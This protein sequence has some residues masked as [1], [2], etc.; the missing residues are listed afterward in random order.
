VRTDPLIIDGPAPR[1]LPA[2]PL[3]SATRGGRPLYVLERTIHL[4]TKHGW[5]RIP[6]GYVTDFGSI[7][8]LATWA[9][10]TRMQALGIHAW[11]ALAHD[12]GYA[13]GEPGMRDVFDDIFAERMKVDGVPKLR[14][15]LMVA[16][17]KAGGGSGYKK[18]KGWWETENFADPETGEPVPPPFQR[19]EAFARAPWGLQ[20]QPDF[21]WWPVEVRS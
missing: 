15:K 1:L 18:A 11:A 19:E 20:L 21:G 2:R 5:E 10:F 4:R 6:Q 12:W 8:R 16:A 9:T 7:P 13:I 14:R 17:V 3:P